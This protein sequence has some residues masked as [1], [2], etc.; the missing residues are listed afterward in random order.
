MSQEVLPHDH[1]LGDHAAELAH[2]LSHIDDFETVS[3]LFKQLSDPTRLRLFW[4][5]C[6]CRECVINLSAMMQMSSPALSHHLRCL[7]EAGLVEST[8]EGKEVYYQLAHTDAARLLHEAIEQ[9][10]DIACPQ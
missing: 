4:L 5:L 1:G 3:L 9:V 2:Q 6:H 7:K 8:R 10:M